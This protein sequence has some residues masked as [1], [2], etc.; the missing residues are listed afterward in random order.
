MLAENYSSNYTVISAGPDWIT[1][2]AKSGGPS[3]EFEHLADEVLDNERAESRDV[4]F[5]S[6][7]GYDGR[8]GEGFFHGR[9]PDGSLIIASGRH[10]C[11]LAAKITSVCSN[12]SRLDLQVTLWTHGEQP[13]LGV[14]GYQTL[15]RKRQ[16]NGRP[17]QL[18][19]ITGYPSG[20]TFYINK[21]AS[22]SFGRCYDKATESKLGLER[23]VWRFE[24]E[25]KRKLAHAY[26]KRV[27]AAESVSAF[28]NDA[29]QSWWSKKGLQIPAR[30]G[31][32]RDLVELL[33]E[34]PKQDF[35]AYAE[36]NLSKQIQRGVE[37]FGIV[38]VLEALKLS[39]L[40]RPI[41]ERE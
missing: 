15:K 9:R 35:L 22:D 13:H 7:L 3:L 38:R 21:R 34:K 11:P 8:S 36:A 32:G 14:W 39:H 23:T 24:C 29:V 20:E 19:L 12:V 25:F 31:N 17:G 33:I 37:C 41:D 30:T 16:S 10:A 1:A 18:T 6:R 5:G 26:A 2:T 28:T 40:V 27:V 4:T